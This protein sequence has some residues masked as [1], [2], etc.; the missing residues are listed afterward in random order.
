MRLAPLAALLCVAFLALAGP[1][2]AQI[3]T[4]TTTDDDV[5]SCDPGDCSVREALAAAD[6]NSGEDTVSIPP[7]HYVLTQ[8]ELFTDSLDTLNVI[9]HSA[10]DTILDAAGSSRVFNGFDGTINMSH[11]MITGGVAPDQGGGIY[12]DGEQMT[13]DHMAVVGN[14]ALAGDFGGQGGGIFGDA[15]VTISNSLIAG[16]VADG[17]GN[18]FSGGQGGG[19]FGNEPLVLTNVTVANNVATPAEPQA[20]FPHSQGGGIFV[21]ELDT[22]FTHTTI[23]G[24]QASGDDAGGGVF[25]NDDTTMRNTLIAGNTVDGVPQN[26]VLNDV[27]TEEGHNLQGTADCGFA[28]AGDITADPLLGALADNGGESDTAALQPG[29]PAIDTAGADACVPTD[30]RD[31]ARPQFAGCDIGAFEVQ[32]AAAAPPASPPAAAADTTKPKVS[33]AGVRA[34]CVS[35]SLSIRVRASD[36]SGVKTT[37]VTLDG[38]RIHTKNK[39][40]FTLKINVRKLKAGRHVLRIVT[41]DAAGNRTSTRRTITRCAKRAAKPRRQAAPRFTG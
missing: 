14:K 28:A 35:R 19:I 26:C 25:I 12:F 8:G 39:T 24:D 31:A 7:G 32:P 40:R 9:G 17:T 3:F 4:V 34:A 23:S 21:N 11:L 36:A 6:A 30:Q 13:L 41:T 37:R 33:V 15:P 27:V 2:S 22:T 20:S 38:K 29:S 1:A 5:G 10:R 18:N 16:N